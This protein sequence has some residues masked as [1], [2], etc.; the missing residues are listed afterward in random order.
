MA[1]RGPHIGVYRVDEGSPRTHKPT[2]PPRAHT[3]THTSKQTGW[4]GTYHALDESS[5]D[6]A[7]LEEAHA[8]ML[9]RGC[10]DALVDTIHAVGAMTKAR[11]AEENSRSMETISRKAMAL[12]KAATLLAKKAA[13]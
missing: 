9:L 10:T 1:D 5:D 6:E 3:K 12:E 11:T 13:R 8:E 2:P 7:A 4:G